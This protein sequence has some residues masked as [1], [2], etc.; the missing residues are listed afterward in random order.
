VDSLHLSLSR[1]LYVKELHKEL[2]LKQLE[3][4]LKTAK[5][6][7]VPLLFT[8]PAKYGNDERTCHF[9]A[10]DL[11]EKDAGGRECLLAIVKKIDAVLRGF[12]LGQYYYPPRFH[13]SL[14]WR[15]ADF[16]LDSAAKDLD[17]SISVKV[18]EILMKCG[19]KIHK[20]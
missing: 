6:P 9:L 10:L 2:F 13:V 5:L 16:E 4:S 19:N 20:L 15:V 14:G 11:D 17:L 1:T 12:G 8:Q 18:D 7:Q 3:A